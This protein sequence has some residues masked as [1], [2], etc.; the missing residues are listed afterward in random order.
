[1]KIT[2]IRKSVQN[3]HFYLS[4]K[5]IITLEIVINSLSGRIMKNAT[6]ELQIFSQSCNPSE[7]SCSLVTQIYALQ[8]GG[9]SLIKRFFGYAS[10]SKKNVRLKSSDHKI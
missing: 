4:I 3:W 2:K 9:I 7:N 5:Q 6:V 8:D 1:M 10:G